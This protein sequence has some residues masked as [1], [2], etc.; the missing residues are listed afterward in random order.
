MDIGKRFS[1]IRVG[2]GLSQG[3]IEKRSGLLRCYISR[4]E[5]GHTVPGF[6]TL[7][8]MAKALEI[9]TYQLLLEGDKEPE[10]IS[11]ESIAAPD[12]REHKLVSAFRKL[13]QSDQELIIAM[14][15]KLG[16]LS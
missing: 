16:K 13:N 11:I 9:E 3:D 5:H 8:R 4:V 1:E 14:M 12:T 2:K 7:E 6:G 15:G 10:P